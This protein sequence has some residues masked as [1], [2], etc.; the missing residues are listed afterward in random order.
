[1]MHKENNFTE[2][3]EQLRRTMIIN[4]KKIESQSCFGSP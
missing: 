1:M 3:Y 4:N 2:A